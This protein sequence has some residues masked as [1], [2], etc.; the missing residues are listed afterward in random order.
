MRDTQAWIVCHNA[1]ETQRRFAGSVGDRDLSSVKRITNSDSTAVTERDQSARS[2]F[3]CFDLRRISLLCIWRN[4]PWIE[5]G[6][7]GESFEIVG[8]EGQIAPTPEK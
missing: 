6:D 3:R 2:G 7:F 4:F 1:I 8:I 5:C